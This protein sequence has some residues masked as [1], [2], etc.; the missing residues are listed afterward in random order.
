M[1]EKN[2]R[3][4][5][6]VITALLIAML[7]FFI[8]PIIHF[9]EALKHEHSIPTPVLK[10]ERNEFG[11]V[12]ELLIASENN[13]AEGG[14]FHQIFRKMGVSAPVKS[15]I[16]K[17]GK[18][19]LRGFTDGDIYHTYTNAFN[20]NEILY[21]VLEKDP[22][23]YIIIDLTDDI[24]IS[25]GQKELTV[26]RK[27]I[28]GVI[29]TSFY[30]SLRGNS[31]HPELLEKLSEIYQWQIDFYRLKKGD[32]FKFIIEEKYAGDSLIG[33]PEIAGAYFNH[34]GS[35]FYAIWYNDSAVPGYYDLEGKN[36]KKAFLKA[37]LDYTAVTSPYSDSR[38]HPILKVNKPH[39]GTDYAAPE[40]TP[41]HTIADGVIA[42]V[43]YSG[44]NGN[45]VKIK[46]DHTYETQYLH[47][48]RIEKGIIPG[49][50]IKQ[51][52]VIG[53]VGSTGLATGPHLCFRFWKNGEQVDPSSEKMPS[54]YTLTDELFESFVLKRDTIL[55]LLEPDT[56]T[57]S[58]IALN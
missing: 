40:G 42:G 17:E 45:Y 6:P 24:K 44:G 58:D 39:Y 4:S 30:H 33:K 12:S 29:K 31:L 36:V 35:E 41:I 54:N 2:E 53:F 55:S 25:E 48:S 16:I 50:R 26:K 34:N 11:I 22:V 1:I 32:N 19:F 46:H 20:P 56:K 52:D 8:I 47:M 9:A 49:K 18:E 14:N 10:L 37:P 51:G 21:L 15:A 57:G 7:I 13:Y 28:D 5:N 23:N 27:A 43:G 38:L 3:K